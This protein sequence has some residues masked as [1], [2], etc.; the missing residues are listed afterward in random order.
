M[1]LI[2]LP[3]E[4]LYNTFTFL[5]NEEIINF[6]FINSKFYKMIHQPF[7]REYISYRPH[8]LVFDFFGNV[9]SICN[10]TIYILDDNTRYIQCSHTYPNKNDLIS[11]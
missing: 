9:C 5:T 1:Q 11:T 2:N 10:Q 6:T 3:S 7:F 8:P 4:L